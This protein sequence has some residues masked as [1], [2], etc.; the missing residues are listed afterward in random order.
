M[1]W[2]FTTANAEYPAALLRYIWRN[3]HGIAISWQFSFLRQPAVR[4]GFGEWGAF[5]LFCGR[6]FT[7]NT[8][9]PKETKP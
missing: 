6:P 8:P 7:G 1:W 3:C 4:R 9:D 2:V 5:M